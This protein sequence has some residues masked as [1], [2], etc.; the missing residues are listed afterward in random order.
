MTSGDNACKM[1][2]LWGCLEEICLPIRLPVR[3]SCE[4]SE[5]EHVAFWHKIGIRC[6]AIFRNPSLRMMRLVVLFPHWLLRI[7]SDLG[8]SFPPTGTNC[9][10]LL[11]LQS[12]I[13]CVG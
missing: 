13:V 12:R 4:A 8:G 7:G 5:A 1:Q 3:C 2:A 11:R 6:S 9:I 10:K